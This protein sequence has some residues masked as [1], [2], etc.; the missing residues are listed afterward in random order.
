M[1]LLDKLREY[2][3]AVRIGGIARRYFAMNAFDG[4]VTIIG[5]LAGS[6]AAHIDRPEI[7]I[8]TGLATAVAMGISG[9]WGAYLTESAERRRSLDDLGKQTLTD[10]RGTQLWRASRA[11]VV[12]VTL[13]DG[14]SPFGASVLVLLPFFAA[15]LFTSMEQVYR[16]SF[17]LALLALFGL[18]VFLGRT[19]RERALPYGLKTMVAGVVAIL[20]S[21]LLPAVA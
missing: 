1:K 16:A 3:R 12:I 5:V 14:L 6:R 4:V 15:S 7:V 8:T 18:G 17:A 21:L 19:A 11:A 2:D 9:F 10:L 13:V 20:A